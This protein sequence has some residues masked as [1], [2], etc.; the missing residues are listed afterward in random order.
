MQSYFGRMI[1]TALPRSSSSRLSPPTT[2]PSP[3]T[4]A[5]GVS[6]GVSM[7]TNIGLIWRAGVAGGCGTGAFV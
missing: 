4:F 7:T 1:S 2:S 6:S 5:T 3:P